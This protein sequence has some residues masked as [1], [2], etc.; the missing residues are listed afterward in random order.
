MTSDRGEIGRRGLIRMLGASAAGALLGLGLAQGAGGVGTPPDGAQ[1]VLYGPDG[2]PLPRFT[3]ADPGNVRTAGRGPAT[4]YAQLEL[5]GASA[6]KVERRK[7]KAGIWV[8][9]ESGTVRVRTDGSEAT[10][11]TGELIGAGFAERYDVAAL[12]VIAMGSGAVVQ[13]WSE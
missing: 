7:G 3:P 2:R 4:G 10:A 11:T 8:Q 13:T 5:G 1:A 6:R 9:V 12:S